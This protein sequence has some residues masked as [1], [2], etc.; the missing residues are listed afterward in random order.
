[1]TRRPLSI[2]TRLLPLALLVGAVLSG[3]SCGD[4]CAARGC[5]EGT[6]CS[7]ATDQCI[8]PERAFGPACT[9][10]DQCHLQVCLTLDAQTA[11]CSGLCDEATPC[12]DGFQC[13]P[14]SDGQG[15]TV[16]VCIPAG[17][18]PIGAPCETATD[19]SSALCLPLEGGAIC[20]A[21]CDLSDPTSCG[22]GNVGCAGFQDAQGNLYEFCVAGGDAAPGQNCPGGLTDCDLSRSDVCLASQD[23][24]ISFCT[25]A[26]PNGESDCDAVFE[27]GCCVDLGEA[28]APQP[29]CFPARFCECQP[30]CT[31]KS[32]GDDGCGGSCGSCGVGESCSAAGTCIA[33]TPDC[34][35]KSCGDD[36]CGG[37]CG[38][39]APGELCQDGTCTATCMPDCTGKSCGDDGCGGLCGTCDSGS[40]CH[41]GSCVDPAVLLVDILV[42]DPARSPAALWGLGEYTSAPSIGPPVDYGQ[43]PQPGT[44][45]EL[46]CGARI[47]CS[48]VAALAAETPYELVLGYDAGSG[49][50]SC[51][52]SFVLHDAAPPTVDG[53]DC[54]TGGGG[55]FAT[56]SVT[57]GPGQPRF[58]W[59]AP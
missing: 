30:D 42:R 8:P 43:G 22:E 4:R 47:V 35:G 48:E 12:P 56:L 25:P 51:T 44:T 38:S 52:A 26:C 23:N 24:S 50:V 14:V 39:C 20:S 1:M 16:D 21:P 37:S 7:L 46:L 11:V 3:C 15:G 45:Q 58:E 13:L 54:V 57:G 17:D 6:Y 36:G 59:A 28:G 53:G 5:P 34:T 40:L 55:P 33:C 49:K 18:G 27:G 32:C 10:P 2:P 31:G 29:F 9:R 19:C 41:L